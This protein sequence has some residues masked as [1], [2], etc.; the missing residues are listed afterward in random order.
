MKNAIDSHGCCSIF[1]PHIKVDWRLSKKVRRVGFMVN[2]KGRLCKVNMYLQ[3]KMC[4]VK[5]Y[6]N[7]I[8]PVDWVLNCYNINFRLREF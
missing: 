8:C 2:C 5:Y 1:H 6:K 7:V 3:R 4:A